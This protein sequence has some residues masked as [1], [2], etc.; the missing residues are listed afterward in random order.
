[1]VRRRGFARQERA[2]KKFV[3]DESEWIQMAVPQIIAEETSQAAKEKLQKRKHSGFD[4]HPTYL[5]TGLFKCGICNANYSYGGVGRNSSYFYYR[6]STKMNKG[7]KACN[8]RTLK[9]ELLDTEIIRKV[10]EVIFSEENVQKFYGFVESVKSEEKT[11]LE[12]R[13]EQN[14]KGIKELERKLN[15]YRKAVESG[16]DISLV[17]DPMNALKTEKQNLEDANREVK[18]RIENQPKPEAFRFTR[19]AYDQF[20]EMTGTF[21]E[22]AS[23]DNKRAFLQ[24]FIKEIVVLKDKISIAY[25]PPIINLPKTETG[26]H[27]E[28]LYTVGMV[29]KR[30]LEP[31]RGNPH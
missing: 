17:I 10:S 11:E 19:A 20:M 7:G 5:L 21:F 4:R 26:L 27:M 16:I 31:L 2:G 1:M 12:K 29:P 25:I 24:K 8:N 28:D 22:E 15:N 6:C 30:G 13:L 18:A 3:K 23:P 9:G 14:E